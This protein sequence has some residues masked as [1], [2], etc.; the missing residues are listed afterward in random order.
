MEEFNPKKD[1]TGYHCPS[2]IN[3]KPM[4]H[5]AR[6]YWY[7]PEEEKKEYNIANRKAYDELAKKE[8]A[9]ESE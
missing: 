7:M 6:S 5:T 8:P 3:G 2:I 9:K 4:Y 1:Y